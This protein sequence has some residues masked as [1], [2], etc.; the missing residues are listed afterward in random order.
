MKQCTEENMTL[1][2]QWPELPELPAEIRERSGTEKTWEKDKLRTGRH[3]YQLPA[4]SSVRLSSQEWQQFRK[5]L[6]RYSW[7]GIRQLD[8]LTKY[9]LVGVDEHLNIAP[10][11][12]V[13]LNYGYHAT[14]LANRDA[15]LND[16]LLPG[17]PDRQTSDDCYDCEGNIYVCDKLG[18][19]ADA[20]SA[21]WW[22]AQK[23]QKNKFGDP[24]WCIVGIDFAKVPGVMLYKDLQSTSGIIIG[25]IE[26]VPPAAITPVYSNP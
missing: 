6:E 3:V 14:R 2:A 11:I 17:T 22:R 7:H 1:D 12:L 25:G 15:I 26:S 21:H 24:D 20:G 23:A 19:L 8:N 13:P 9:D 16:G 4:T 5:L 18:S 10:M